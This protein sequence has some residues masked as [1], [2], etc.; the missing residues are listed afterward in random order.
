MFYMFVFK[1]K[2]KIPLIYQGRYIFHN[3]KANSLYFHVKLAIK[4]KETSG[5]IDYSTL[6]TYF[7]QTRHLVSF[8]FVLHLI[9][10][11]ISNFSACNDKLLLSGKCGST[12]GHFQFLEWAFS[13]PQQ[14]FV[15][16]KVAFPY[17]Y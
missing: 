8:T 1:C 2:I 13:L 6:L 9:L 5:D 16:L 17:I 4:V 3:F 11:L 10:H 14:V 7:F 15:P 12:K